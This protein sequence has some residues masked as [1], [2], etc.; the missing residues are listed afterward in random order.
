MVED[1]DFAK[2]SCFFIYFQSRMATQ[3]E[4]QLAHEYD[5]LTHYF[6]NKQSFV[7]QWSQLYVSHKA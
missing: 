2:N 7:P 1:N 4:L 3:E 5:F 6:K